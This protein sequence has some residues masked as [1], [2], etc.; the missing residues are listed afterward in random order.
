M[1]AWITEKGYIR[2]TFPGFDK[3]LT[4]W[5]GHKLKDFPVGDVEKLCEFLNTSILMGNTEAVKA[6]FPGERTRYLFKKVAYQWLEHK[7]KREST[8]KEQKCELD[9]WI[10]P[11]VG[12]KSIRELIRQDFY[13]IRELKGDTYMALKLRKLCQAILRWAW[14]EGMVDRQIFVPSI[15]VPAK[16]TPYIELKDRWGIWELVD[17]LHQEPL[18]LSIE[19]GFRIG[20]IVALQWDCMDFDKGLIRIMRSLSDRKIIEMRKGGDEYWAPLDMPYN[21][22]ATVMLKE[23]RK[24]RKSHWIFPAPKGNHLWSNRISDSFKKAA[25]PYG[26]PQAQ[27]HH[28][29]HSFIQDRIAEGYHLEEAQ[30][31]VGHSSRTT[32]ERYKGLGIRHMRKI[33]MLSG[34]RE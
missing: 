22:R 17:K 15:K 23:K 19:L 32:T 3:V 12:D 29:R 24:Y 16:P 4:N 30:A 11:Q 10:L 9:N 18:M 6:W 21:E 7:P 25:R 5:R 28:C 20:E 26:L 33:A 27:L 31:L 8:W 34:G 2:V 13:W 14:Q 1:P